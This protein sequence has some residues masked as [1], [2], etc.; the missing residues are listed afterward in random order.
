MEEGRLALTFI[1]CLREDMGL[2]PVELQMEKRDVESSE[3]RWFEPMAPVADNGRH[4]REKERVS[5]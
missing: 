2:E 3:D 4:E 1:D 5:V